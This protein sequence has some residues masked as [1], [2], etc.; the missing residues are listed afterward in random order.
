MVSSPARFA[1][2]AKCPRRFF[3]FTAIAPCRRIRKLLTRR[4]FAVTIGTV[5]CTS[6]DVLSF[7]RMCSMAP[8]NKFTKEE[9]TEAALRVVRTKGIDCLTA[10]AIAGE[11]GTST[12]PVFTGF[13]SMDDVRRAVY[14]AA[15]RVY[16][17]YANAGLR[18]EIPFLGLG[19]QYIRFAREEPEL[20]RLLFLSRTQDRECGAMKSMRHL[21]ELARPALTDIYR[22]SA[23]EA[24]VYFR[25]MWLVVHGLSTLIVTGD[26]PYS[27]REIGQILTGFS[28]SI[29]KSVREIPGFAA[30]SFDRD[31][32]FC[33]LVD[34]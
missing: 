25:D 2:R 12:R 1:A 7:E 19:M 13:G 21:Q 27:D 14:A 20:Y 34:N 6:F 17:G 28:V 32:L 11:L 4:S 33:A 23:D 26:C 31:A 3:L 8:K 30:G 22:I 10:K 9:M 24:D 5:Q 18:A 16:D 29:F 15:V